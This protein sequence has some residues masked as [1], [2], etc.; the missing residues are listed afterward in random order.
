MLKGTGP[1]KLTAWFIERSISVYQPLKVNDF[2]S[3]NIHHEGE[4]NN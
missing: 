2:H 1:G 4:T 3:D